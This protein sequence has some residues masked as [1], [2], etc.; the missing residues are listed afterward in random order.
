VEKYNLQL[1]RDLDLVTKAVREYQP[2]LLVIDPLFAVLGLDRRGRFLKA[3]DDQSVRQLTGALKELAEETAMTVLLIRH[4]NK[5]RR[6]SAVLRGS[7]SVAIA[8]QARAVLLAAK[9]PEDPTGS[10]V[11]MV[12]SNLGERP[13]SLRFGPAQGQSSVGPYSRV[14]WRGECELTTEDLLDL[15]G[16]GGV[17][18]GAVGGRAAAAQAFLQRVLA[19]EPKPWGEIVAAGE[20]EGLTAGA[21]RKARN[22]LG[23]VQVGHARAARWGLPPA[24]S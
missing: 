1:P 8:G 22:G 11:A 19:D 4:L 5:N 14:E 23:L 6:S 12:K 7:G 9:D 18:G 21:L 16:D 15:P 13:R 20:A 10:V 24:E 3:N 17:G 2:A